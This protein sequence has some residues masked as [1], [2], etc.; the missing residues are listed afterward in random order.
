MAQQVAKEMIAPPDQPSPWISGSGIAV[1][2]GDYGTGVN[3][4][5]TE[6]YDSVKYRAEKGE[7]GITVPYLFRNG[8]GVVPGESRRVRGTIPNNAQG[9]GDVQLKGKYD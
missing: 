7:V 9:F 6:L 2:T 4:T 5:I 3:T 8:N 1:A